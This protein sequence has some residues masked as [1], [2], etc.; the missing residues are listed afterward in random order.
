M[1]TKRSRLPGETAFTVILLLVSAFMLWTAYGISGFESLSSAG[2]VSDG[3]HRGDAD[4]RSG[5]RRA[6]LA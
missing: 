5:Q 6:Y 2:V 4:H 3:R 1:H